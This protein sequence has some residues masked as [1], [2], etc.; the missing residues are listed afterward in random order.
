MNNFY[1]E[2][3]E[4]CHQFTNITDYDDSDCVTDYSINIYYINDHRCEV[5]VRRLD[6][7]SWRIPFQII[8]TTHS[9]TNDHYYEEVL[10]VPPSNTSCVQL[11]YHTNIILYK[12]L[13]VFRK[14][15]IP[16][17]ILQTFNR[18]CHYYCLYHYYHHYYYCSFTPH[19]EYHAN[20][21]K[22]YEESNPEYK[23]LFFLDNDCRQLIKKRFP[24]R[25]LKAYD[26]LV[27]K[28]FRADLF[29]YCALYIFG[30]CYV[31][32][33]IIARRPFR[34]FINNYDSLL[35]TYDNSYFLGFKLLFNGFMCS[36]KG[37]HRIM[38][39]IDDVVANIENHFYG[40]D[41]SD[42]AITGPM[43]KTNH[44]HQQHHYYLTNLNR[45]CVYH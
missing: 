40:Y 34:T 35:V 15:I 6:E 7:L 38:K 2:Q 8:I 10:I 1:Y 20:A 3:S 39:L 26:L 41:L 36:K 16:K 31:D 17:K 11:L 4:Y 29:R 37:D 14:Q 18:Y 19:N 32:H 43:V 12:D 13:T 28:A 25:V 5:I 27:P 22:T 9:S 45:L 21:Y 44:H 30:G 42:L 33:K 24:I 23:M